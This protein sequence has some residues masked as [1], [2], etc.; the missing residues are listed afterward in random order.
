MAP[1]P[2]A[3]PRPPTPN[4]HPTPPSCPRSS[5]NEKRPAF[6]E[7]EDDEEHHPEWYDRGHPRSRHFPAL[8]RYCVRPPPPRALWQRGDMPPP[9]PHAPPPPP[10]QV[11]P[12]TFRGTSG[13]RHRCLMPCSQGAPVCPPAL[14][15]A[16]RV[17]VG[18]PGRAAV[19]WHR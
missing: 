10:P 12:Q 7:E 6:D 13:H 1:T 15:I 11:P 14:A 4:T 2:H 8:Q 17:A 16:A 19:L 9:H 18:V 5:G 3:P